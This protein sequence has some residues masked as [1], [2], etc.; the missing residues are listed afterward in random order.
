[1]NHIYIPALL[2]PSLCHP[3]PESHLSSLL[4]S[5]PTRDT[6]AVSSDPE[7]PAWPRFTVPDLQYLA[8]NLTPSNRRAVQA[9]GMAFWNRYIPEV[10]KVIGRININLPCIILLALG[11]KKKRKSAQTFR[12]N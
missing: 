12:F 3:F 7:L 8:L 6:S 2:S 10:R 1:M 11:I 5:D 9:S 4:L